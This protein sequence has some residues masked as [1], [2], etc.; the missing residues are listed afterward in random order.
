MYIHIQCADTI[1]LSCGI[2]YTLC[3]SFPSDPYPEGFRAS[4]D[5]RPDMFSTYHGHE[6]GQPRPSS[7]PPWFVREGDIVAP[8]LHA[9][10]DQVLDTCISIHEVVCIYSSQ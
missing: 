4:P 9:V 6:G 8:S 1:Q 3:F 7:P 2:V 5:F 10:S